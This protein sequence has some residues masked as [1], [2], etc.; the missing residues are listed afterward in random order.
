[1]I[2]DRRRERVKRFLRWLELILID[3]D[4]V[5]IDD[6]AAVRIGRHSVLSVSH[7]KGKK[8]TLTITVEGVSHGSRR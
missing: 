5:V 7:H 4:D 2:E 1:M 8:R 3:A 6:S